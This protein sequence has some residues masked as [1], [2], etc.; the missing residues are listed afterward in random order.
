MRPDEP[1]VTEVAS[2][3]RQVSVG[4]PFRSH[5]YLIDGPD[6]P[7]AFDAGLKDTGAPILAAAGGRLDRVILSHAHVDHRGGANELGAPVYCHPNEVADAEGDAGRSYTDFSLIENE[8]VRE[9]VPQLHAVWD[10]GPV[11]IAGTIADGDEIA[12]FRVIHIPGHAPGQIALFREADRLLLAADAIYTLDAETGQP[13]SARVPHPFSNWDTEM[14][15]ESV[16][17]LLPLDAAGVWVGHSDP[18]LGDDVNEQL[19]RAAE[20]ELNQRRT[21]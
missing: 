18:V 2:G 20:F 10:G 12:G 15:R 14:A 19:E 13:A 17:R 1:T 3:V 9:L 6:G 11:T 21:D 7:I 16:R 5:I 4:T 8:Q